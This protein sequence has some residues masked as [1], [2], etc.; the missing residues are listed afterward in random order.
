MAEDRGDTV[1]GERRWPMVVAVL[2]LMVLP[3]AMP[4]TV[5]LNPRWVLPVVEGLLLIVIIAADPG[6]IDRRSDVLRG[7]SIGLVGVLLVT[8]GWATVRLIVDLVTGAASVSTAGPL[9]Q[10]GAV[11][12]LGNAIVFAILYWELDSG[13]PAQRAF[14]AP[15]YPDFAFP[16]QS[17]PHL[18]PPGWRAIFV[19]Y[20]YLGFTNALAFSPTDVMPLAHWAKLTMAVQS[21]VSLLILGLVI[22]RAV[23][24]LN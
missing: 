6:R 13:G 22:A 21:M 10:A 24:I 1:V 17:S 19:D 15:T 5:E 23:N 9:L 20:L 12:W 11:V 14:R 18:A 3:Y 4:G 8:V 7:L 2:F 16:E